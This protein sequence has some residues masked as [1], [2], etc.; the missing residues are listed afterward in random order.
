MTIKEFNNKIKCKKVAVL[1]MGVSN[2]PLIKFL[3]DKDAIITVFD[4]NEKEKLKDMNIEY[5]FGDDYLNHLKGFD[6]IFR[7]PGIRYDLPEIQ[8]EVKNGCV[9]TSEMETFIDL[10]PSEVIGVT[11]SD[12]KTTT[13]TLI[14]E[15]LKKGGY[16]TYL[17]GNI[18]N[19]LLDKVENMKE[20][21]KVVVELS[22]FQLQTF[23]KSVDK[24]VITNLSPNHLDIHK[25]MEEYIEAKKN[26]FKFGT[27]KLV[28]N[29]DNEIT[30]SF[31]TYPNVELFSRQSKVDKGAY[32]DDEDI[33]Y[34]D[35]KNSIDIMKTT[36]IF[37]PG[38]HNIE[39]FLSAI[40][41]TI[42]YVDKEV[43]KS[44][45]KEFKGVEHRIEFV[46]EFNGVKYYNDS[47][48][49]SPTRTI[50]GLNS[51][52]DKV[53][54]IA[55]G[56]DKNLDYKPL[57]E[58]I[59]KHV[60]KLILVGKTSDK[61]EKS[62]NNNTKVELFKFNNFEKAVNKAKLIAKNKDIVILSPASAAFDMFKDFSERGNVYKKI[63][64]NF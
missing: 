15:I 47:I 42:D 54:L 11:G 9:L 55:G 5:I 39:N 10:C 17:G 49:S 59:E 8:N 7:S 45:A 35:G 56:Y 44:V 22:S 16:N 43:I 48:A 20:T 26:I 32:I 14:Y 3:Y 41:I 28:L 53:I 2:T 33:I 38:V 27:K 21:D 24:A 52:K 4:K 1:G 18:G 36:D 34:T 13:T 60:K 12:G 50:A 23:K 6:Y 29:K 31:K 63:V 58:V 37:I 62:L 40:C 19:P 61:I 51:F 57:G 64:N 30:E 46:R 25:D